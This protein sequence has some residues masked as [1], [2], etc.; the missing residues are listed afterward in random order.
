MFRTHDIWSTLRTSPLWHS[1][2]GIVAPLGLQRPHLTLYAAEEVNSQKRWL[3]F[4]SVQADL[5]HPAFQRDLN[6]RH[7]KQIH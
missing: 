5:G 4:P 7:I 6:G 3:P 1:L 2:A